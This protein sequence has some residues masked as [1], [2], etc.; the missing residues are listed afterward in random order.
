MDKRFLVGIEDV[1]KDSCILLC[2]SEIARSRLPSGILYSTDDSGSG[3]YGNDF[4]PT[5]LLPSVTDVARRNR[6]T[7][8]ETKG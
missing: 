3:G 4:Y 6:F 8:T 5:P 2:Q 1:T 7:A